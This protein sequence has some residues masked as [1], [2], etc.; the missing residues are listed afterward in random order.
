MDPNL[1]I[2]PFIYFIRRFHGVTTPLTLDGKPAMLRLYGVWRQNT[3]TTSLAG[4]AG[5]VDLRPGQVALSEPGMRAT[6]HPGA[7]LIYGAFS[8][9]PRTRFVAPGGTPITINDTEPAEPGWRELGGR[10]LPILVPEAVLSEARDL[11]DGLTMHYWRGPVERFTASLALATWVLSRFIDAAPA[12][13][14]E[15]LAQRCDD[16][17]AL[18]YPEPLTVAG[19]AERLRVSVAHLKRQY[20]ASR[21]CAPGE[22]LRR[23]RLAQARKRLL[24]AGL[25]P[26]HRRVAGQL[27]SIPGH[28]RSDGVLCPVRPSAHRC[29]PGENAV[30][31]GCLAVTTQAHRA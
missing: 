22:A 19:I 13:D 3:G 26:A 17:I 5:A 21:C 24:R 12:A 8:L 6:I 11:V 28:R 1:P 15:A 4:P 31:G 10:P 7:Q 9:L 16:L 2:T 20:R 27:A 29:R 25:P 14:S 23:E 18:C 30:G